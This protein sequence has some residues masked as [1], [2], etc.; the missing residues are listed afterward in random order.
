MITRQEMSTPA[1]ADFS[2][3]TPQAVGLSEDRWNSFAYEWDANKGTVM[4]S[5]KCAQMLG[6][7]EGELLTGS[8]ILPKVHPDDIQRVEIAFQNLSPEKPNIQ[9]SYRTIHP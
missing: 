1:G 7:P 6:V 4:L 2:T 5:G 3:R 8:Q 9:I